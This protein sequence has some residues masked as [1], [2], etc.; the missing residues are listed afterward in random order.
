MGSRTE[1]GVYKPTSTTT[2]IYGAT[3]QYGLINESEMA[4]SLWSKR[5]T[6]RKAELPWVII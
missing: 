2:T 3:S 6:R 1:A 4:K 5:R